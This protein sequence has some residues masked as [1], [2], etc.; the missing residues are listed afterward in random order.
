MAVCSTTDT[1]TTSTVSGE[2]DS[3]CLEVQT[4]FHYQSSIGTSHTRLLCLTSDGESSVRGRLETIPLKAVVRS[5]TNY[6]ALSYCWGTEGRSEDI[7][8][9]G[10]AFSITRNLSTALTAIV[11]YAEIAHKGGKH[12]LW[13]DAICIDQNSDEE[14]SAQV[15]LMG[16]IYTNAKSVLVWLG[17]QA[18]SSDM[19]MS[20]LSYLDLSRHGHNARDS[21]GG[22]V[23]EQKKSESEMSCCI[24]QMEQ[25][26]L[27]VNQRY[28]AIHIAF[29]HILD[30]IA[31]VRR[32]TETDDEEPVVEEVCRE[33][34]TNERLPEQ[35]DPFWSNY[36]KLMTRPWFYRIWTFQ[37]INLAQDAVVL[38]GNEHVDWEVLR[39]CRSF[40]PLYRLA[41]ISYFEETSE[42]D[43]RIALHLGSATD[44]FWTGRSRGKGQPLNELLLEVA[45]RDTSREKDYVYGLL[46]LLD[47]RTRGQ[48]AVDYRKSDAEVYIDA[49]ATCHSSTPTEV[50]GSFWVALLESFIDKPSHRVSGLPSWCPDFSSRGSGSVNN[51]DQYYLRGESVS[52]R[53]RQRWEIKRADLSKDRTTLTTSPL[54]LET[55][56]QASTVAANWNSLEVDFGPDPRWQFDRL[57]DDFCA[58]LA[59]REQM[60]SLCSLSRELLLD[61]VWWPP[62]G[63]L[64]TNFPTTQLRA[65]HIPRDQRAS[66]LD[67]VEDLCT[68]SKALDLQTREEAAEHLDIDVDRVYD[69]AHY[70]TRALNGNLGRYH[71]V[72][73]EGRLGHSARVLE[74]GDLICYFPQGS[75]LHAL[76]CEARGVKYVSGAFVAGLG[77]DGLVQFFDSPEMWSDVSL[78]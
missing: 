59:A 12:Y 23:Y 68:R 69:L 42:L 11:N 50:F 75:M 31:D 38:C 37:E 24:D 8:I 1:M 27:R 10:Q 40:L 58:W 73:K 67:A 4:S 36:Y 32:G 20:I 51:M 33:E 25:L 29:S 18:D 52:K 77:G 72:T 16:Q 2:A 54:V 55:V 13:V 19:V 7:Q 61:F 21:E 30:R 71:F 65:T 35:R 63:V 45:E 74:P 34:E 41:D 14:R 47:E 9:D 17:P 49:I 43:P 64:E 66:E 39:L 62:E 46:G 22:S 53:V 78:V 56:Q 6:Y 5:Q 3:S 44:S 15:P 60:L 70:M 76:R 48:I 28:A 57:R 26:Q